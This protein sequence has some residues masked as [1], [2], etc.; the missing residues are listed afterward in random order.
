[1]N[2]QV[3]VLRRILLIIP[4]TV[5]ITLAAF[6]IS[7]L[8]PADPVVANLSDRALDSPEIVKAFKQEWGLD[9]P[10]NEQ[11]LRYLSL[12][13]HGNF[14]V[15]I[16][17]HRPVIEDLRQYLPAT[18][19][20][21]VWAMFLSVL[22]GIPLGVV[23][24]ANR[25]RLLDR[26]IRVG[27]LVGASAPVFWLALVALYLLYGRLGWFPSPGGRLGGMVQSP[28]VITGLL[29]VDAV[30]AGRWAVLW[31]A[32]GHLALPALTLGVHQMAFITRI[33]RS[34]M[35]EVIAQE[36]IRT[37][38]SKGLGIRL[39]LY[40]HAL[41][42][43]MIPT[44]AYIGLAFGSLLSGAVIIETVFS[45][46]GVGRYAFQSATTLDFPAIMSVAIVV[47]AI[48]VFVNLLV[49]IL[50][51]MIDPRIRIA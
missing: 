30:L 14:G 23:A 10:I 13:A 35:L 18:V 49:D 32:L 31:D 33:T 47:A 5:G 2:L 46:P 12:I 48:Y 43:A 26:A 6:V 25:E 41:R 24:A 9:R 39:I 28:P 8:V 36:Y 1:M 21:A 22:F 42:N 7:H 11:Y 15:S 50:H 3:Y 38:W 20:L 16:R 45:W 44:I 40:R 29:T 4:L 51:V 19:E 27:T 37:A 17:S 34:S